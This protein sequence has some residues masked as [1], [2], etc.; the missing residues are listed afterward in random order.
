MV[1]TA[2]AELAEKVL[3]SFKLWRLPVKPLEIASHEGIIIRPGFFGAGFDARIEYY[4]STEGFCI[5]HAQPGGWRTEGR[6]KFSL[7]HELGH[8][9]LPEHRERLLSGQRHNSESDFI[10][11]SPIELQA[12]EFSADLLMPM[13]LFRQALNQFRN[14]F[15]DLDDL[16]K[17]ADQLGTSLTSTARRYCE[18]DREACTIFFSRNGYMHWGRA[19]EDM[20]RLGMYWCNSGEPPPAGSK[21]AELWEKLSAGETAAKIGGKVR[22]DVWFK[23]PKAEF[24]WEEAKPL[25][26]GRVITQLTP[27]D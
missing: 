4:P 14:G 9:Y 2:S 8:F 16:G 12:D 7:G 3:R 27:D 15:C 11:G 5:F 6:V 1:P 25:G 22:A 17:L 20:R 10:S 18:S 23:W 21:T 13:P 19:S 24:L 26:L